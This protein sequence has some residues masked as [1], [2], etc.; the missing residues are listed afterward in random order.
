MF[1][2][3]T[4]VSIVPLCFFR[5]HISSWQFQFFDSFE[6]VRHSLG[7]LQ[8]RGGSRGL[9][10]SLKNLTSS[11]WACLHAWSIPIA[12]FDSFN[13]MRERNACCC[14]SN[15]LLSH[16]FK[17]ICCDYNSW[18]VLLFWLLRQ[19]SWMKSSIKFWC[20]RISLFRLSGSVDSFLIYPCP[21][22]HSFLHEAS[23]LTSQICCVYH[24]VAMPSHEVPWGLLIYCTFLRSVLT[25]NIVPPRHGKYCSWRNKKELSVFPKQIEKMP[26]SSVSSDVPF[27]S[28]S[29]LV[30]F[31][32]RQKKKEFKSA[33]FL[34][35]E[36]ER[37]VLP[38][39]CFVSRLPM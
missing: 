26:R 24:S 22:S 1:F 19:L 37:F 7:H 31:F 10:A 38:G 17:C 35:A 18:L 33:I 15:L 16:V 32:C 14:P 30:I 25:S 4:F 29:A 21:C 36:T 11:T 27:T 20:S 2:A 12:R 13:Q 34:C 23:V 28:I 6:E 8:G 39:W 9:G 5:I 3:A